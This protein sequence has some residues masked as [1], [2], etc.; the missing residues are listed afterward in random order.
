MARYAAH[1]GADNLMALGAAWVFDITFRLEDLI[2][3]L[4]DLCGR[5]R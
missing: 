2:E 1:Y 3:T 5:P 4:G